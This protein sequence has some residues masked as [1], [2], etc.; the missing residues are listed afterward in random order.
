[1]KIESK[2][3]NRRF[4][5]ADIHG[6]KKTLEALIGSLKLL[7]NDA[8]FFLGDYIDRGP[9]SIGVIDIIL[10]LQ[11]HNFNIFTLR[12]NHEQDFLELSE[13]YDQHFFMHYTKTILKSENLI[14]KKGG[15]KK[16]VKKFIENT[17]LYF[18]LEDFYLVHAGFNFNNDDFLKDETAILNLRGWKSDVKKTNGKKIIHGHQPTA[19]NKI[20]KAIQKDKPRI[21]LDN[22]CVY[23]KPHRYYDFNKLGQLCCL[24]L[25]SME[26]FCQRNI[27]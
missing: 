8:L 5:I 27:E 20:I 3:Y 21:P 1:M 7:P 22:G 24:E 9:D 19:H 17:Q 16:R 6:C 23:N 4:V 15:I 10:D 11:K 14:R 25:N 2:K 26:L 13:N 18:E 12:G